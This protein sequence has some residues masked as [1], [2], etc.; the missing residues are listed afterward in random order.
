MDCELQELCFLANSDAID[1]FTRSY[2]TFQYSSLSV[3]P[4]SIKAGQSVTVSVQVTN[5]GAKY[6]ADEVVQV[7]MSW[8]SSVTVAPFRQ[9]VGVARKAIK[10]GDTISVRTLTQRL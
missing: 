5:T 6:T 9:L 1:T 10:P 7:Y 3:K 8:P 2:S 4:T